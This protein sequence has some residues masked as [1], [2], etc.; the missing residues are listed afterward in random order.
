MIATAE[1]IVTTS[2]KEYAATVPV[3]LA[4]LPGKFFTKAQPGQAARYIVVVPPDSILR[5]ERDEPIEM[6][7]ITRAQRASIG[8]RS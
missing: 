8:E 1:A 2:H 5:G 7:P 4:K 3:D 6:L